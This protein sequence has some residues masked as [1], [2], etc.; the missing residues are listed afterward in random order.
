MEVKLIGCLTVLRL[1]FTI[2][3]L[4]FSV[5]NKLIYSFAVNLQKAIIRWIRI[6]WWFFGNFARFSS[7]IIVENFQFSSWTEGR[8]NMSGCFLRERE[9]MNQVDVYLNTSIFEY[10][11]III[12]SL[13]STIKAISDEW[14]SSFISIFQ[15]FE[16]IENAV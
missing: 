4:R 16:K 13:S 7:M 5:R 6:A 2:F 3:P 9:A 1:H 14:F 8:R 11:F 10:A 12:F 15:I